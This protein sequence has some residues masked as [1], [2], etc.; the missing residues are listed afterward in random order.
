MNNNNKQPAK[1]RRWRIRVVPSFSVKIVSSE[2]AARKELD[3][4]AEKLYRDV[5]SGHNAMLLKSII[6]ETSDSDVWEPYLTF[7]N[8]ELLAYYKEVMTK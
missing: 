7:S 4:V 5:N 1:K 6:I 2:R 3:K 8:Q